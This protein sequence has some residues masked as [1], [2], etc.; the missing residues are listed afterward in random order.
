MAKKQFQSPKGTKDVLPEEQKYWDTVRE[1]IQR[2]TRLYGYERLDLPLFEETALFQRGVGQGTDIVEKEMYT[3]LDKGNTSMT[4]RPEFTASVVRAYIQHG[5][6]SLPTPVKVWS[7]GPVFRYERPQ[8]GRFRQHTQFNVEALGEQDPALDFE[9]MSVAWSLYRDLGFKQLQF[10]INSIGCPQ[11]RPEYL[12]KLVRYYH[13]YSEKICNDCKKRLKKNPLRVLDC[14]NEQCQPVIQGAPHLLES[15]CM[16]CDDH[17]T[18]LQSYLDDLNQPY[19]I[20]HRLVRGL[21]YYTKTVFEVWAERIGAQ[22]AVC[23]G[24]RYDKLAEI[25]GGVPTPA[26]GFASG[27][28]RIV[29]LLQ[30]H[31][32]AV[33][34]GSPIQAYL[35]SQNEEAKKI[36][37][38]LMSELR[39]AGVATVMGFGARSMKAQL[40]EANRRQVHYVLI[41]GEDEL[42]K[43]EA[44]IKSMADSSQTSVSFDKVILFFKRER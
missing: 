23:G 32:I 3:F 39:E 12:K 34:E 44:T 1:V 33:P 41:L 36:A 4:L 15:L 19:E 38:Q 13:N 24:G 11:C 27:I 28:E 8:A 9:M 25:L 7:T 42:M 22:N 21:D 2:I 30:Q 35:V 20:N 17:F 10:Q 40:R 14:K 6:A 43:R 26:V 16:E 5:M 18:T 31:Q 37:V 29:L